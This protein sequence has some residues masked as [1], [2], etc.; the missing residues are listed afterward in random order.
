[1]L[2]RFLISGGIKGWLIAFLM[3]HLFDD[4]I[5]PILNKSFNEIQFLY[6]KQKGKIIAKKINQARQEGDLDE[7]NSN[8]D[9][10]FS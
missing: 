3:S 1:L 6:D 4:V 5:A 10:L 2:A 9:T 8:I 7:Y